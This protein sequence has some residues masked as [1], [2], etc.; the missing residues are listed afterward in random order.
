MDL[1]LGTL[2]CAM[3]MSGW[4]WTGNSSLGWRR[5]SYHAHLWSWSQVCYFCIAQQ[6]MIIF[7]CIL[8][9]FQQQSL[10]CTLTTGARSYQHWWHSRCW[11]ICGTDQSSRESRLQKIYIYLKRRSQIVWRSS[12]SHAM[13]GFES[14]SR[15]GC[16]ELVVLRKEA[17]EY[18]S[19]INK[20]IGVK[21][22][23]LA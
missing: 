16:P 18:I 20:L 14:I 17:K 7:Y 3:L 22:S 4:R 8:Y 23:G 2:S 19:K 5:C 13:I 15:V 1:S 9:L 21:E 10:T 6:C 12:C 11:S